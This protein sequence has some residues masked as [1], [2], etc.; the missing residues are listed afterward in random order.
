MTEGHNA[1]PQVK[2]QLEPLSLESSTISLSHHAPPH[3]SDG[4]DK[5]TQ[6][7]LRDLLITFV[8]SLDT[9][10][11][12]SNG[13]PDLDPNFLTPLKVYLKEVFE[14]VN[15]E[16]IIVRQQESMQNYPA[17]KESGMYPIFQNLMHLVTHLVLSNILQ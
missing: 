5:E 1:V 4:L 7:C 15:F 10:Q 12:L 8:N 11:V 3:L 17:S 14:K 6:L 9:D 13:W 16:S 2:F